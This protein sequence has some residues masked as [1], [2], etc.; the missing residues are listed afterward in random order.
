M[1][2]VVVKFLKGNGVFVAGDTTQL[3][4]AE[5]D[6]L[7][8][9]KMIEILDITAP[10]TEPGLDLS[11]LPPIPADKYICAIC[12]KEFKTEKALKAH[13]AKAHKVK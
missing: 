13:K 7:L 1:D 9:K 11:K 8:A 2:K 3:D 5:A 6:K 10:P 4:R 12:G